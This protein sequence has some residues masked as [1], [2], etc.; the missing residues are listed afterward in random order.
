MRVKRGQEN[1][2]KNDTQEKQGK[3]AAIKRD[4]NGYIMEGKKTGLGS[5][6]KER[7]MD[8]RKGIGFSRIREM[9][10]KKR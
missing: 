8:V 9:E 7:D 2:R 1:D 5:R 10:E 3:G 6:E 4:D